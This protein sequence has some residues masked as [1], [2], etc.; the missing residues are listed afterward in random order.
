MAK[1]NFEGWNK[2]I[3]N[4]S[5]NSRELIWDQ[6]IK[7][8]IS[9]GVMEPTVYDNLTQ[10]QI[11]TIIMD[12][13]TDPVYESI[14]EVFKDFSMWFIG[15]RIDSLPDWVIGGKELW[16]LY[17]MLRFYNRVWNNETWIKLED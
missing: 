15:V 2:V 11:Q 9:A 3:K 8:L 1:N 4:M 13:S 12:M 6:A 5:L 17:L 10:G 16:L 14:I 7:Y